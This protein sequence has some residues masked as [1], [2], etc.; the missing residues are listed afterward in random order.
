MR[1]PRQ[2]WRTRRPRQSPS[3]EWPRRSQGTR[4]LR[5]RRSKWGPWCNLREG[6][7]RRSHRGA[8][9][10]H[11]GDPGSPWRW[12]MASTL[13]APS[14][15]PWAVALLASPGSLVPPQSRWDK[16]ARRSQQGDG[17]WWSR[18]SEEGRWAE[19][20]LGAPKDKAEPGT[21]QARA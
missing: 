11:S 14:A 2:R 15:P 9:I 16:G 17:P 4:E 20:E 13:L 7:D 12:S 3:D 6:G 1:R 5:W 10:E 21:P 18:G 8:G 19:V